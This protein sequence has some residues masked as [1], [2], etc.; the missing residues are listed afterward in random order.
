MSDGIAT[1]HTGSFPR[2]DSMLRMLA[3]KEP[4]R[5]TDVAASE[6]ILGDA[7]RPVCPHTKVLGARRGDRIRLTVACAFVDRHISRMEEY[8][9]RRA[10]LAEDLAVLARGLGPEAVHVEVNAADDVGDGSASKSSA[11]SPAVVDV[12]VRL[13]RGALLADVARRTEEIVH[14]GVAMIDSLWTPLVRGEIR[15]F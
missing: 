5:P 6:A 9:E 10:A 2:P 7:I 8:A 3:D 11:S 14:E 13:E 12:R 4:G 1:T 15:L